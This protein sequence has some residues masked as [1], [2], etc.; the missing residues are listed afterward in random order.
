MKPKEV[1][2][3]TEGDASKL[4]TWS[5]VPYYLTRTL[6][7]KGF[8]VNRINVGPNKIIKII[9]NKFIIKIIRKFYNSSSEYYLNRTVLFE[10]I[11]TNK[12]KRAVKK[13]NNTD[14]FISTSYSFTPWQFT[15]KKKVLFCDWTIEYYYNYF[16]NREPDILEQSAI[17]RQNKNIEKS[18]F[19]ISLFPNIADYMKVKYPHQNVS[20]LGNVIN[21]EINK[22]R[23]EI[24]NNKINSFS[25]LFIGGAKYVEGANSL[26]SAF[27]IVKQKYPNLNLNIIGMNRDEF[28]NLPQGINCYGYLDKSKTEDKKLYYKLLNDAKILVNTTPKWAAFSATVEAMYWYTPIITTPY[29]SFIE[30][31]GESIEFGYY[32]EKNDSTLISEYILKVLELDNKE[33]LLLCENANQKVQK[34]TWA[35]YVDHF[36][37]YIEE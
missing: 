34:F 8:I 3:F 24:I 11:V 35:N 9:F 4:R 29:H 23:N 2:V 18:D 16:L 7:E 6:E 33:Y 26:I 10:K 13:Y 31:F 30:T 17:D 20:Y 14:F 1:T 25:L 5:N 19:V 27:K 21:S 15:D 22:D 28:E 12:M 32:C 37:E 36:L